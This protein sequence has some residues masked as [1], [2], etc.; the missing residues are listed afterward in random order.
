MIILPLWGLDTESH[1]SKLEVFSGSLKGIL[2][3]SQLR[4]KVEEEAAKT[5]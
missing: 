5:R 1:K 2:L 4:K 3:L